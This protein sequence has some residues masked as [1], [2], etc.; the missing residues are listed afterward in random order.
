MNGAALRDFCKWINDPEGHIVLGMGYTDTTTTMDDGQNSVGYGNIIMI[1]A[2]YQDP[3]TGST[4]LN[5][6]ST[7]NF[8]NILNAYGIALQSP[9]RL[10]NISKQL[11]LV[12][13]VITREMD[14][15]PQIRPDNNY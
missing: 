10:M 12:F 6:F 8:S 2:R 13:R 14:S 4:K 7:S 5:P 15:L 1:Q 3:T 11:N 9:R